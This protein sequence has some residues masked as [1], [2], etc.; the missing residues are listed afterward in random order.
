MLLLLV[1]VMVMVAALGTA[2]AQP[3]QESADSSSHRPDAQ[4]TV[5]DA[6]EVHHARVLF[7]GSQDFTL[8]AVLVK[9]S[10]ARANRMGDLHHHP[11]RTTG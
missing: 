8:A 3:P 10:W 5:E 2:D 6:S 1:A 9:I 11:C 7:P 4:A